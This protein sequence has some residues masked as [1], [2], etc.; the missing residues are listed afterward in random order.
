M[1]DNT[2]SYL[3]GLAESM[4][5]P[6]DRNSVCWPSPATHQSFWDAQTKA[7]TTYFKGFLEDD[8]YWGIYQ[9]RM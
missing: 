7:D 1:L 9:G 4:G 5:W 8:I 6:W 2:H 3:Q